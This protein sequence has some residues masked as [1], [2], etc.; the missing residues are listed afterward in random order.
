VSGV[1][2]HAGDPGLQLD[3]R[4]HAIARRRV[5]RAGIRGGVLLMVEQAVA[6]R[7][8]AAP[9]AS[10]GHG[11]AWSAAT[12][13]IGTRLRRRFGERVAVEHVEIFTP[14]SFEFPDVLAAIEAG[15]SLPIVQVDGRIVSEGGKLSES[16]I[17]RAV[18][19]ALGNGN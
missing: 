19:A 13:Y 8:F 12:A 11:Q 5:L 16:V 9:D 3:E 7:V 17:A 18:G 15:S 6:V 1:R 10:C 14:R 4:D 2:Q